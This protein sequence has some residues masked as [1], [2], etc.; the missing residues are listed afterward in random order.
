MK[1][2]AITNCAYN[3]PVGLLDT[4]DPQNSLSCEEGWQWLISE[5][6]M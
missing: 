2:K 1:N 3:G 5:L 4:M 6:E